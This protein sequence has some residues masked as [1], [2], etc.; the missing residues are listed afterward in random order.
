M[1]I[2]NVKDRIIL[3][4]IF[5]KWHWEAR[6]GLIWLR[7]GTGRGLSGAVTN[8]RVPLTSGEILD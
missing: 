6:T 8:L 5:R 1:L 3:K 4:L 2:L 7:I